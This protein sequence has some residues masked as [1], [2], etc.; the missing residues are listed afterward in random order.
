MKKCFG[1]VAEFNPFHNGHAALCRFGRK[2]GATHI[3]AV[4]SGNTVQ[5]GSFAITDKRIRAR[6][7]LLGGVDLVLELPLTYSLS[8][9]RPFAAG[10][11]RLLHATGCVDALCFGSENGNA[12]VLSDISAIIDSPELNAVLKERLKEGV[13]FARARREAAETLYGGEIANILSSP[14]NIL[15]L[16][17][18]REARLLDWDAEV[19]I[20][21][22]TGVPHD[23]DVSS[24]EFASASYLRRHLNCW[25]AFVPASAMCVYT[26]AIKKGLFPADEKKLETA[27]LSR[28]RSMAPE[29]LRSLPDLSE[30]LENRLYKAIRSSSSL[31]ELLMS[32]KT[33]RYTLSRIRRLV[34]SAFLGVRAGDSEMPPPY[35]RVLGFNDKGAELLSTMKT[36]CT[37]PV[38]TSLATLERISSQCARFA[39][40]EASATDQF[41]LSLPSPPDCGYEYTAS[42]VY[43]K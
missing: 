27:I 2:N 6:A 40:L 41:A 36:S 21:K 38:H 37:S 34:L 26:D 4:M 39:F 31:D 12:E 10:A 5:R 33:K 14:N 28:L 17:Y 15:A 16:E 18:L 20:M 43:I 3:L 42:A 29:A 24:G 8:S 23:G 30:G 25:E 13:T 1:I 11:V 19:F 22:R 35:A 7:A 32:V 9:A